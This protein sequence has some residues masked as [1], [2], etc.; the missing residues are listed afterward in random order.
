MS[1]I[2]TNHAITYTNIMCKVRIENTPL[3]AVQG[4][5]KRNL[6]NLAIPESVNKARK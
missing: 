4:P 3:H 5:K 2:T 1:N 6:Q